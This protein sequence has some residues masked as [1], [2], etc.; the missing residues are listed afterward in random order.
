MS[1][2]LPATPVKHTDSCGSGYKKPIEDLW[3]AQGWDQQRSS[4]IYA[5]LC[6]PPQ[7]NSSSKLE[8]IRWFFDGLVRSL[9]LLAYHTS[10]WPQL[11]QQKQWI[12][13]S[14][15]LTLWHTTLTSDHGEK[16]H[17]KPW[18]NTVTKAN[19]PFCSRNIEHYRAPDTVAAKFSFAMDL[20]FRRDHGGTWPEVAHHTRPHRPRK[21]VGH[22]RISKASN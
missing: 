12:P 3:A 15:A 20:R 11:V 1:S 2:S 6:F 4:W 22:G 19:C 7:T 17:N 13:L 21:E 5:N 8:N 16:Q 18:T 9:K 14:M 10:S